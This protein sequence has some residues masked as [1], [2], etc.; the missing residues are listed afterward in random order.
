MRKAISL[1]RNSAI[2]PLFRVTTNNNQYVYLK[3]NNALEEYK[4]SGKSI[5]TINRCKGLGEQDAEELSYC[6]LD[7]DTRNIVQLEVEDYG[8]TD[9]V[10]QDLYGKNVEPRVKFLNLHAEEGKAE[11]E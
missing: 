8:L 5:K 6:L 10:F 2:P 7:K 4:Q 9:K 11:Y 1:I 3:D